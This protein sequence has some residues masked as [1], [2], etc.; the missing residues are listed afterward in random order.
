[1]ERGRRTEGGR[2]MERGLSITLWSLISVLATNLV[3]RGRIEAFSTLLLGRMDRGAG[4]SGPKQARPWAG[5]LVFMLCVRDQRN[6]W[7]WSGRK[8]PWVAAGFEWQVCRVI[9]VEGLIHLH[10]RFSRWKGYSRARVD[11]GV[12][13]TPSTLHPLDMRSQKRQ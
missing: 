11:L 1:M 12:R 9:E 10:V 4:F 5:C 8:F 3:Y 2:R 6:D 7:S 13:H